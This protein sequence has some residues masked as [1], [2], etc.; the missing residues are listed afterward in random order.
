MDP[1]EAA[2]G[3]M[4]TRLRGPPPHGP[5]KGT[6]AVAKRPRSARRPDNGPKTDEENNPRRGKATEPLKRRAPNDLEKGP[7]VAGESLG[8]NKGR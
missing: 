1:R 3:E 2:A 8:R 6:L 4:C 7:S 5:R